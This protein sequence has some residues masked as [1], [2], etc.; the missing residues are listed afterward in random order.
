MLV[1]LMFSRE[2]NMT[3]ARTVA[4]LIVAVEH[5]CIWISQVLKCAR[6]NVHLRIH[7]IC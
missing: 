7:K 2:Q 6:K 4:L 5:I 1:L 3:T